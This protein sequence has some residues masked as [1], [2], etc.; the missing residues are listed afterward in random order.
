MR[1][2]IR[3][4]LEEPIRLT[5]DEYRTQSD[6]YITE[7]IAAR[8]TNKQSTTHRLATKT[9]ADFDFLKRS[10]LYK[11]YSEQERELV[12]SY[13]ADFNVH[14]DGA[15]QTLGG[16]DGQ[17]LPA[18]YSDLRVVTGSLAIEL[19]ANYKDVFK[20]YDALGYTSL[21]SMAQH[22]GANVELQVAD[23]A[24][25]VVHDNA[26]YTD[27]IYEGLQVYDS[28]SAKTPFQAEVVQFF[29]VRT[30]AIGSVPL[31]QSMAA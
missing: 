7:A 13:M 1:Q 4:P 5:P 19:F 25:G 24:R 18:F 30:Q 20:R 28:L 6:A 12:H 22:V 14:T 9:P 21:L 11:A 10:R 15:W 8:L 2:G 23:L 27:R 3:N 26:N 17:R 31:G 16:H 29:P